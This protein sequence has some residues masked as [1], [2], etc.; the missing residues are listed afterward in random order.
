MEQEV[1][2]HTQHRKEDHISI[3]LELNVQSQIGPGFD[4]VYLVHQALPQLN[5]KSVDPSCELFGKSLQAPLLVEG[6]TGGTER[7]ADINCCIAHVCQMLGLGMGLG[8]QRAMIETPSLAET[9]T[10]RSCAPDILLIGNLG[11]PQI[12]LGY[13][14]KEADSAVRTVDAD[15]L[16]I[17]LNPLQEAV[18]PEGD[19]MFESGV[20]ALHDLKKK[21]SYPLIA[22]ETGAGIS[23]ET[24]AQLTFL[25][26]VDVGGLGGTSFS[27]VEYYR[28]VGAKKDIA[29]EFWNWGLPTAV[30]IVECSACDIAPIIASGGIRTGI[31]MAKAI[32]LGAD[33]CGIALPALKWAVRGESML[34]SMLKKLIQELKITMFLCG[35]ST[36]EE[37]KKA[38]LIITGKTR[39]FLQERGYDTPSFAQR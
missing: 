12:L 1:S 36:L 25:D 21:C 17:H 13:S 2:S 20:S 22:K 11:L 32:A 5:Y 37:L 23:R 33:C 14:K 10:V 24:A 38:P 39:E 7:A 26:G 29:A 27:A 30:S 8:S 34:Q 35:C 31:D 18:Q 16:A 9:Y 4:D 28:I 19:L 6:M 15:V 3:C